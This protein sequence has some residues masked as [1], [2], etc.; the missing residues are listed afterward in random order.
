MQRLPYIDWDAAARV[1]GKA[2]HPGPELTPG[3]ID[4][5]VAALRSAARRAPSHIAEVTGPSPPADPRTL[6]VDPAGWTG[7]GAHASR[8]A[9]PRRRHRAG[10]PSGRTA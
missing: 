10:W 8:R 7:A 6:I 2:V 3:A 9:A 1:G 4:E 5:V